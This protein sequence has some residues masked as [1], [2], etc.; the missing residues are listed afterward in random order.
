MEVID[1]QQDFAKVGRIKEE[2]QLEQIV[3]DTL[4][5]QAGSIERH[6]LTIE[7]NFADTEKVVVQKSKLIHILINLFKNAKDAMSETS[8]DEKKIIVR[9]YQDE[10]NVYLDITDKGDGIKPENV[11]KIFNHG[12]TT[13]E[14]GHGYGLHSCANYMTEMGG[15]INATS[16][17]KGQ[18]ATFTLS[19]PRPKNEEENEQGL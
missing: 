16:E 4:T 6:N 18:G 10:K 1:A 5:L 17:G 7:K 11:S 9:T 2:I 12:F 8:S 13:K 15:S 3:Q 14:E 19:F